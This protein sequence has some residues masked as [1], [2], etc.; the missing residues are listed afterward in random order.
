MKKHNIKVDEIC[1]AGGVAHNSSVILQIYANIIKKPIKVSRSKHASAFGM[2]I[3]SSVAAGKENG[4]YDNM[5]EA[6][7]KMG[8]AQE[9][10]YYPQKEYFKLYDQIYKKYKKLYDYFANSDINIL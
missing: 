3:F 9:I 2:A 1:A 4:G 5:F 8:G 6:T 10:C 7:A